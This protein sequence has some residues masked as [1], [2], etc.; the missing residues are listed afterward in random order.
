[1]AHKKEMVYK[2]LINI[3]L[4]LISIYAAIISIT[5]LLYID[6]I[7]TT[8]VI[9]EAIIFTIFF[10]DTIHSY[11]KSQ[12]PQA[13]LRKKW[14][15]LLILLPFSAALPGISYEWLCILSPIYRALYA[16]K[17]N[18][19]LKTAKKQ[20]GAFFRIN[21]LFYVLAVFFAMLL[22]CAIAL[23]FLEPQTFSTLGA[24]LWWCL[25]TFATVGY[26][27]MGVQTL[28][29]KLISSLL[30]LLGLIMIGLVSSTFT[31]Y[32][33]QRYNY[34]VAENASK[35]K[36][37][38]KHVTKNL[39]AMEYQ[40]L[41]QME[42]LS[43]LLKD[44]SH[45]LEITLKETPSAHGHPSGST[46][47]SA[48]SPAPAPSSPSQPNAPAAIYAPLSCSQKI[49]TT[50]PSSMSAQTASLSAIASDASQIYPSLTSSSSPDGPTPQATTQ[51][52]DPSF[53]AFQD[54]SP[55][56]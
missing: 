5:L 47:S 34:N 21:Y 42:C 35:R 15:S 14:P 26:G 8:F 32:V 27:D 46:H 44:P 24:S 51:P 6:H 53:P 10:F 3:I 23:M 19:F 39:N 2:L 31:L 29:A 55:P 9:C 52:M 1:M 7:T 33:N 56:T 48:P 18:Y 22:L 49:D 25:V 40:N 30:M 4:S 12:N 16:L 45:Q 41:L 37:I 43:M 11:R 13:F 36:K 28:G 38:I 17:L 50:T 20:S 54:D